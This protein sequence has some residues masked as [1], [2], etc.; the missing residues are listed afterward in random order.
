VQIGGYLASTLK[1]HGN[2]R[3]RLTAVQQPKCCDAGRWF[4]RRCAYFRPLTPGCAGQ[5]QCFNPTCRVG[6]KV[7]VSLTIYG[8]T[9]ALPDRSKRAWAREDKWNR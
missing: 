8:N 2:R 4:R 1:S 3:H 9:T 7:V 5:Q 6:A